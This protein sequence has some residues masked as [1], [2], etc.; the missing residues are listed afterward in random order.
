MVLEAFSQGFY[1]PVLLLYPVEYTGDS[2]ATAE[3]ARRFHSRL[4]F[5]LSWSGYVKLQ[6]KKMQDGSTA[7]DSIHVDSY[8]ATA[9]KLVFAPDSGSFQVT[10]QLFEPGEDPFYTGSLSFTGKNLEKVRIPS[11][12]K[13]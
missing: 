1:R 11:L 8:P 3:T 5:D 12:K 13:S 9:L 10:V 6:K 4:E 7:S 2:S